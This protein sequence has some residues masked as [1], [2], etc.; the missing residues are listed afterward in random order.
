MANGH[1]KLALCFKHRLQRIGHVIDTLRKFTQFVL[2]VALDPIIE[3]AFF[4]PLGAFL[5]HSHRVQ[6]SIYHEIIQKKHDG[7]E[8]SSHVNDKEIDVALI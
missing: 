8:S 3:V 5:E 6:Q 7:S 1:Q 2:T 4:N